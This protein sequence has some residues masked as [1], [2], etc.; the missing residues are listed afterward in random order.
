MLN[1]KLVSLIGLILITLTSCQKNTGK[2]TQQDLKPTQKNQAP[3]TK[4]L[5]PIIKQAEPSMKKVL[6]YRGTVKYFDFEGGFFGV[7]TDTGEKFLTSGLPA[8]F[9]Q[10]GAI[11]EFSGHEIK[12]IAT[13]QQWGV[14]FKV[15]KSKLIKPG[16]KISDRTH[17][18]LL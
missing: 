13:I 17:P 3:K 9:L 6:S 4:K 11:I 5:D 15:E 7:V 18:D 10:D 2:D 12:D 14:P 16:K 1:L 8:E